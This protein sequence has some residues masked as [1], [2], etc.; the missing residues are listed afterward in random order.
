MVKSYVGSLIDIQS[1]INGQA[2]YMRKAY[3]K[4]QNW[5]DALAS[6]NAGHG[7]VKR[8]RNIP[9]TRKYVTSILGQ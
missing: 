6:Y 2:R 9:E 1:S 3:N 5:E 8:W 7:N 4:Y